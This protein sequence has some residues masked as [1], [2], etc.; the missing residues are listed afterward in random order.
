MTGHGFR[1][2]GGLT[3]H[4]ADRKR[5]NKANMH[6]RGADKKMSKGMGGA[7]G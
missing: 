4:Q 6:V 7:P 5:E 3:K 2:K 1:A